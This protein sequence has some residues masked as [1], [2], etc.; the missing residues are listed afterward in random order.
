LT[1][2]SGNKVHPPKVGKYEEGANEKVFNA[3]T[4]WKLGRE[5]NPELEFIDVFSLEKTLF[6]LSIMYQQLKFENTS[7]V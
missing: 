1:G 3:S 2:F 7:H 4:S 5:V 6:L